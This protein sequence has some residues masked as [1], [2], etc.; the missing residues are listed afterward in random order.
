MKIADGHIGSYGSNI[1]AKNVPVV[2]TSNEVI[3]NISKTEGVSQTFVNK[4]EDQVVKLLLD[5]VGTL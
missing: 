1:S 4:Q 5:I 2:N 3:G